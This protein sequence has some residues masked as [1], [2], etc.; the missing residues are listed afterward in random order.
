MK[1]LEKLIALCK[2]SVSLNINPHR[3]VYE[4]IEE[5]LPADVQRIE[6]FNKI[7][8]KDI[9]VEIIFYPDTPVANYTVY[10]YDI[11]RA[12]ETAMEIMKEIK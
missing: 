12:I 8:E 5:Y 4:S 7:V 2:G 1:E 3:D 9:L 10:D 6:E 11:K